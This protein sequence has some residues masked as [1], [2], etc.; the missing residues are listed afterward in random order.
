M[1]RRH[2]LRHHNDF[3]DNDVPTTGIVANELSV[4]KTEQR[5]SSFST[6][7][8]SF[9]TMPVPRRAKKK[10]YVGLLVCLRGDETEPVGIAPV[11]FLRI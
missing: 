3:A 5:E 7:V 2:F 11:K 4:T 8:S 1:Q 10:R 6:T 9:S